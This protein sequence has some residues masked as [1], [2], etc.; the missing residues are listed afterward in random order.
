MKRENDAAGFSLIELLLVLAIIGIISAVAIP[1]FLGQRRRARRIGD[2]QSNAQ[3]LR[4]ALETYKADNGIYGNG[5]YNWTASGGPDTA[6]KAL[7]PSTTLSGTQMNFALAVSAGGLTYN[8]VVRDP[9]T[10][11]AS[12]FTINQIGSSKILNNY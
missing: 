4:M 11:N 12:V 1:S 10:A 9:L 6:A 2:A 8:L 5:S 3:I 7:L